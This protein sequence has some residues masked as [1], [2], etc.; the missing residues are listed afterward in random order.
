MVKRYDM[1][2]VYGVIGW[3]AIKDATAR[4][5]RESESLLLINLRKYAI[6]VMH[7]MYSNCEYFSCSRDEFERT[8]RNVVFITGQNPDVIK[9]AWMRFFIQHDFDGR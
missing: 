5:I 8:L 9:Y 2:S 3:K 1:S 4:R 7:D 6:M